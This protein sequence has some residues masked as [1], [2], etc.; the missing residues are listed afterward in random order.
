MFLFWANDLGRRGFYLKF[1]SKWLWSTKVS[2]KLSV[3]STSAL[4]FYS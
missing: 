1:S 2:E 4:S 3:D